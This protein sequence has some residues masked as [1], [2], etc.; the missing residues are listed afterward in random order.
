M[1]STAYGQNSKPLSP[2]E[3]EF[4]DLYLFHK[5]P[6]GRKAGKEVYN[7]E[8]A[9]LKTLASEKVQAEIIRR[10]GEYL[11]TE[12]SFKEP[13]P[14]EKIFLDEY[15]ASCFNMSTACDRAGVIERTAL[16]ILGRPHCKAYI[17]KML[18]ELRDE[19][20]VRADDVI[21]ELAIIGF[22]DVCQ[23]VEFDGKNVS[24]KSSGNIDENARRAICE[25][26][27]SRDG[28]VK[29]KLHDKIRA[30]ENLGKYLGIFKDRLEISGRDGKAI[31]VAMSPL[32]VLHNRLDEVLKK[33]DL[34]AA[35]TNTTTETE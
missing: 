24:L 31:E 25:I 28:S 20:L 7:A 8:Y 4:I 35:N 19:S 23:F 33:R 10:G 18:A 15:V 1:A 21:K 30:L 22:A 26:S 2:K 9:G 13:S 12:L 3:A 17:S 6:E 14:V 32:D 16:Q 5:E 29:I 27:S 11:L 34:G